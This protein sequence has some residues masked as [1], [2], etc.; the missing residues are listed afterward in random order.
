MQDSNNTY[1]PI[2]QES[3]LMRKFS[4]KKLWY[5]LLLMPLVGLLYPPFYA[6]MYPMLNGVP[7]FIWYQFAWV[8]GGIITTLIVSKLTD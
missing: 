2:F 5:L 3:S 7:F 6:R 4:H 8:F 1:H